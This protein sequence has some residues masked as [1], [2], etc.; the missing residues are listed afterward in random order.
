MPALAVHIETPGDDQLVR[1]LLAVIRLVPEP[2]YAV[3]QLVSDQ[4]LQQVVVG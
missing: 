3:G 4:R 1:A 2:E